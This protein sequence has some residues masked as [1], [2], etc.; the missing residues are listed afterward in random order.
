MNIGYWPLVCIKEGN[1]LGDLGRVQREARQK[2]LAQHIYARTKF[3]LYAV[4][5][6]MQ[7]WVTGLDLFVYSQR[8]KYTLI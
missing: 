6:M 5:A 2:C 3:S 8:L 4:L 7:I 1:Q